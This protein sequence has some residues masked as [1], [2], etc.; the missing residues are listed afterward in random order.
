MDDCG[1]YQDYPFVAA[2]YDYVL[3]YQHRPDVAFYVDMAK[4]SGGP[5]LELGCGTGRVLIPTAETGLEITGF[6]YSENML[7]QCRRRLETQ[8]REV[9]ER[10][11]LVQGDMRS[12]D[13]KRRFALITIPFRPFQHIIDTEDQIRCLE[14]VHRHLEP[15]GRLV[16]DLFC[17]S[18]PFLADENALNEAGEEP[19][20]DL[21]D[22]RVMRRR[23]RI[24]ARDYHKQISDC[25]LIYYMTHPDG[26]E[27]RLVHKFPMRYLFRYEAEHL[28]VRCG[29]EVE[30]LYADFDRSPYG[31]KYPGELIFVAKQA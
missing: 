25:E 23:I 1:G 17:P 8:S 19:D 6:D 22:G 28:L 4:E 7:A 31:S 20:V 13:L 29:F 3:P 27:E 14:S 16:M 26:R 2:T 24:A 11:N 15:G 30:A 9:Q 21:P 18:I 5:V 10:V 12:F